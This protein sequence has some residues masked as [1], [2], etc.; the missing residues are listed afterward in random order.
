MNARYGRAAD[1]RRQERHAHDDL[2]LSLGAYVLGVLAEPESRQVREH[3]AGCARCRAEYS[4]LLQVRTVLDREVA[5]AVPGPRPAPA[6]LPG[7]AARRTHDAPTPWRRRLGLAA[8]GALLA[9]TAGLGGALLA[10]G[11]SG[12]PSG[13]RTVAATGQYGLTASIQFHPAAWGTQVQVT[14]SNVPPDYTCTLTAVGKDGHGEVAANWSSG[15][16][17]GTV[18]VPG[19]VALP[20]ASIDHFEVSI[21]PGIDLVVPAG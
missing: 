15:P 14:M 7:P 17:G 9:S 16:R 11:H 19:A 18:T 1:K 12:T 13:T 2:R 3:L 6:P 8:A 20:A 21:P 10:G 5:A 4:E